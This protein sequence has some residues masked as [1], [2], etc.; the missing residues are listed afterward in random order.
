M[1]AR[2]WTAWDW[3]R[4]M[5]TAASAVPV[6]AVKRMRQASGMGVEF[7]QHDQLFAPIVLGDGQGHLGL[8]GHGAGVVGQHGDVQLQPFGLGVALPV[9]VLRAFLKAT[10][11]GANGP[12]RGDWAAVFGPAP[13]WAGPAWQAAPTTTAAGK[14]GGGRCH[15]QS[16]WVAGSGV[17]ARLRGS[18]HGQRRHQLWRSICNAAD[19]PRPPR[20]PARRS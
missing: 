6:S 13:R 8:D 20:T 11:S 16:A 19:R 4:R 14:A 15:V 2:T 5:R 10:G 7:G 3:L 17:R 9:N 12:T 18:D 1:R